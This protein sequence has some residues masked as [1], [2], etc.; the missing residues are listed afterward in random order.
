M[1]KQ[2]TCD[3]LRAKQSSGSKFL[4]IDVRTREEWSEGNIPGAKLMLDMPEAELETLPKD[5]EIVFQCRSGGRSQRMAEIFE[6]RGFTN[7]ANLAG[8]ILAWDKLKNSAQW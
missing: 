6:S 8:G 2:I 5:T 1:I 4:L 3:D 7:L